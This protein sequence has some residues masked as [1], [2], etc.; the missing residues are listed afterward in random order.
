MAFVRIRA[1]TSLLKKDIAQGVKEGAAAGGAE[2]DAESAGS[3]SGKSYARG[4]ATAAKVG[5]A[6][7]VAI[8]VASVDAAVKFQATMTRVQTQAGASAGDVKT[9]TAQVL[10]LAPATQQGPE[11]LAEALYHLKSVGMDN[12]SAM[13]ALK[14]A[15]DLAAVG[16]ANLEDTTNAIAAAW[17]SG[18]KGAQ[19]FGAAAATVNAIIGAGNMTM[20]DFVSAMGTGLLSAATTFG[21]SLKQ[22]GGALALMTDEGVPAVDA[23][24]RLKMSFSLLAAPSQQASKYLKTIGV[25]GLQLAGTMRSP[26]GLVATIG[27][28][29]QHLDASGMSASQQAI[30]LSRAFGGGRSSSAILTM[31]NN[32]STLKQKQDQINDGIGKYGADVAKQRQTVQAQLDLLKSAFETLG[33]KIGTALLPPLNKFVQFLVGKVVPQV[34]Q[35]AGD[36]KKIL[37]GLGLGSIGSHPKPAMPSLP[38]GPPTLGVAAPPGTDSASKWLFGGKTPAQAGAVAGQQYTTAIANSLSHPAT[39]AGAPPVLGRYGAGVTPAIQ[40]AAKSYGKPAATQAQQQ[41]KKTAFSIGTSIAQGLIKQAGEIGQAILTMLGKIDWGKLGHQAGAD[42][43]PFAMGLINGLVDGLINEA[44]HHPLQLATFVASMIPTGRLGGVLAKVFEKIPFLRVIAPLFHGL[45]TAGKTV[46]KPVFGMLKKIFGPLGEKVIA[47][48]KDGLESVG[49]WLYVKGDDLLGGL[50]TGAKDRLG[51]VVKWFGDLGGRVLGRAGEGFA[52]AGRFLVGEGE[53]LLLGLARGAGVGWRVFDRLLGGIPGKIISTAAKFAR[54]LYAPAADLVK[55]LIA[56][57][58]GRWGDAASLFKG[59]PGKVL[60]FFLKSPK[61]LYQSG[62]D[63]LRG[64][65]EGAQARFPAL[66]SWVRGIPGAIGR[67]FSA[68]GSWLIAAGKAVLKGFLNGLLS[69]WRSVTS[70]ISGIG[71]WIADHKGPIEKDKVLLVPHGK[72]IMDGLIAGMKSRVA[73]LT[74]FL[75]GVAHTITALAKES[76]SLLASQLSTATKDQSSAQK[77]YK[78]GSAAVNKLKNT[79]TS[80]ENQIKKLIAARAREEKAD[81]KGSKALRDEQE[82]QIKS[83]RKLRSA[84]E[85]QIKTLDKALRPLKSELSKLKSEITRLNK[86]IAKQKAAADKASSDSSDDSGSDS[87]DGPP[88]WAAFNQWMT[89]TG[90]ID[91][92]GASGGSSTPPGSGYPGPFGGAGVSMGL[93]S[94]PGWFDGQPDRSQQRNDQTLMLIEQHMRELVGVSKQQPAKTAAGLNAALNGMATRAIVQGNW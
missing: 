44:I 61:L 86:A 90:P 77:E 51:G 71:G 35:F 11:Q 28:L 87:S 37:G 38:G 43:I 57:F 32:L 68:A 6:A 69:G 33:V 56:G 24:T 65:L 26:G 2:S 41:P 49:T 81:S 48:A 25:T 36:V 42:A 79:R 10:K 27:L 39:G 67:L 12:V 72:A 84:Q 89:E 74:K 21:V 17:R 54:L 66:I 45:E 9:L 88:N 50:L 29:K 60:A 8:G 34:A 13:R 53:R 78:Q 46:E 70:F 16:G 47:A 92:A 7:V 75:G 83:L 91:L 4:F 62:T 14:T 94:R 82:K 19:D 3:R 30:L 80:E 15:S 76:P 18:I 73:T 22:V 63:I 52:N 20:G 58:Q 31:I 1:D 55:G 85:D 59:I 40:T 64:L 93:P 5:L 23:A